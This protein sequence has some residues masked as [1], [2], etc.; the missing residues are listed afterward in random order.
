MKEY[1]SHYSVMYRE[2]LG[3][4][5][6]DSSSNRVYADMTFG[7]GGHTSMLAS[8]SETAHVYSTDQDPD[9]LENGKNI[10]KEKNLDK[11]VT[12]LNMNFES[13]PSWVAKNN[14]ELRFDGIL[15][16]LGVSSHHFDSFER[17][18][19]FRED[20]PLDMRM[21]YSDD[22]IPTAANLLNEMD[23]E[24]LANL[25][26]KYGEERLSRRIAANIVEKR[27]QKRIE[28]TKEL[29][30]ICFHAYP[31]H[32]RHKGVHPATRTFQ[33]LRIAVNR[34]LDVLEST[35]EK[36]FSILKPGGRL[37][38]IS[39]HSLEDRIVKHKFKE[40][41]QNDKNIAKIL[42]KRPLVPTEEELEENKRSRSAKLR[43]IEHL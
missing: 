8:S 22:S 23:E 31:K 36:L 9:A 25:I 24:D 38:I 6:A 39:F 13:F 33:A 26:Y 21:N 19:S 34:E 1:K 3:F 17:G 40:I 41:F 2:C 10:L 18:F 5:A 7:A 37:A 28:T 43:V 12:L 14:P 4:L 27:T 42:T 35:I 32:Q 11:R 16:D 29:E 15:M 30:D 20:A